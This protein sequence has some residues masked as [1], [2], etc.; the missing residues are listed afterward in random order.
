[1]KNEYRKKTDTTAIAVSG[2]RNNG[3]KMN[4]KKNSNE[5]DDDD[6]SPARDLNLNSHCI[7][8]H[9]GALSKERETKRNIH[10]YKYQMPNTG[11]N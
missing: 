8:T 2:E 11:M 3:N 5:D 10:A 6:D 9:F 1:M 4:K 7:Y